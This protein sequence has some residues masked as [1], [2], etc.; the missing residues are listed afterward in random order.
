MSPN[1]G[2]STLMRVVQ[3]VHQRRKSMDSCSTWF[4]HLLFN[5]SVLLCVYVASMC[6]VAIF[7]T[8]CFKQHQQNYFRCLSPSRLHVS[9]RIDTRH[10]F[11][12]H[13]NGC[14]DEGPN[15]YYGFGTVAVANSSSFSCLSRT[16]STSQVLIDR[17]SDLLTDLIASICF[18]CT[19]SQLLV[20]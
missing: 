6:L 8:A 11:S 4:L 18:D 12:N 5:P 17:L 15:C 13:R 14:R 16:D 2:A 19:I 20:N 3:H 10:M 9:N 1:S 7:T